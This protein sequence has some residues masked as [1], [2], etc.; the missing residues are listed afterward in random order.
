MEKEKVVWD[1]YY[2]RVFCDICMEEVNANNRDGGCLS[3]KGYTNLG[4]KFAEKVEKRLTRKQ[5]KNKWDSLKKDYTGWM[6]LQNATGLGWDPETKTMD[7]DDDWWKTHLTV[8]YMSVTSFLFLL[9]IIVALNY[10]LCLLCS[11]D[12]IMQSLE[13]DHLPT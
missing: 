1:S 13:M 9:M 7:A 12:Q 11:F 5:F 10:L 8:S 3:K 2:T 6:E 4:D